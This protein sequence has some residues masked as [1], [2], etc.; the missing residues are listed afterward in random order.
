MIATT[1][2]LHYNSVTLRRYYSTMRLLSLP[3]T[4]ITLILY[5]SICAGL[6]LKCMTSSSARLSASTTP[7]TTSLSASVPQAENDSQIGNSSDNTKPKISYRM[8]KLTDVS[9]VS[10][11]LNSVFE[12]D[13]REE[14]G[15][16]D[17]ATTSS[18]G[19]DADENTFMWGTLT[20]ENIEPQLSQ[21]QQLEVIEENLSKRMMDA[22]KEDTLPHLFLVATIPSSIA[23]DSANE[24][25]KNRVI[26]FLEMGTLP[27][28]IPNSP[29]SK[30]E[31]PYIGNVAVSNDVRRRKVGS[32]L[33]K[34]AAK[35]A[36]KWCAPSSETPFPPF[37]FLSVERDNHNA[38]KFYE[39]LGFEELK[40]V[41]KSIEKIYLA[42]E[43]E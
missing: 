14:S 13:E 20:E 42:Q 21:E 12:D 41:K 3:P 5:F 25:T 28:P 29:M 22:K 31:L 32:T 26:G 18:N 1:K 11:L 15:D 24:Q 23:N 43:L 37:L 35:I 27:P 8:A 7:T 17:D 10:G 40:T 16:K 30:V 33:V 38:L 36:K 34:L 4:L 19:D 6:S 9:A 39:R 2:A